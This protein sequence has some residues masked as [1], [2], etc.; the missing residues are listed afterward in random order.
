MYKTNLVNN[1]NNILLY[2]LFSFV[3]KDCNLNVL[4]AYNVA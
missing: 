3:I 1:V 2:T 4:F